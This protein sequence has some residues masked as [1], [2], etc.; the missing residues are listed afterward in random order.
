MPKVMFLEVGFSIFFAFGVGREWVVEC[1]AQR[2]CRGFEVQFELAEGQFRQSA[3]R[4][5][6]WLL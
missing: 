6:G 3:A 5:A 1:A 2:R 4:G